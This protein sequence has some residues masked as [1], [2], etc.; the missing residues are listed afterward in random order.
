MRTP[1]I[2]PLERLLHR[3][4]MCILRHRGWFIY[5]QIVLFGL[6]LMFAHWRLE[7]RA[8]RDVLVSTEQDY[9][10]RWLELKR[11]FQMQ[12]NLVALVESDDLEKNRQFVERLAARLEAEPG[13]FENV[14]FKRD[15]RALGSKGLLFLQE[16]RL[17]AL[18]QALRDAEPLLQ[19]FS[20]VTNL[21]SLFSEVD[22]EMRV[23]PPEEAD[24]HPLTTAIPALTRIVQQGSGSLRRSGIP[25][26]PGITAL[27]AAGAEPQ[28]GEYIH[29]AEGTVYAISCTVPEE[30]LTD[31]A[32]VRLREL[33][34][35]AQV[36][37]PGVNVGVVGHPV[38]RYEERRQARADTTLASWVALAAVAL[39]FIFCYHEVRRPLK[40]T[41]CL[42]V[43]IGYTLGFATLT[44]GHLNILT[45]TVVP[46]LLGLAIDF[47]VH[48][49]TRFEEELRGGSP[50][51]DAID[52]AL[53]VSGSGI[54]TGGLATAA[55]FLAMTL[56]GFK[57]LREMGLIAG[58]GLLVCLAPMMTML[59]ALLLSGNPNRVGSTP[60]P[61]K[62]P[63][64]RRARFEQIWLKRPWIAGG[65][66]VALTLLAASQAHRVR[67]DYNLLNMQSQGLSAV[68]FE[69]KLVESSLRSGLACQIVAGS[70][71]QALA[72]ERRIL[73]LDTVAVVDSIAPLLAG[74][75][76]GKLDLVR[77]IREVSAKV[78]LAPMDTT[79]LDLVLLE[80]AL[81]SFHQALGGAL[82]AVQLAEDPAFER[83]LLSLREAIEDWRKLLTSGLPEWRT[84]KL[85]YF[86]QA[87]FRDLSTMLKAL[88]EQDYQEPLRAED[89]PTALRSRFI[90]RTG[91]FLLQVYPKGNVWER[92]PQE[93][94]VRELRTIDP[95][96]AGPPVR[97]YEHIGLLKGNF[98][99]GA[100][101]A[102]LAISLM[103]LLHFR[104]IICVLLALLPVLVGI[105]WTLG[106]MVLLDIAFNPVN[107][108]AFTLLIG[109][110]VSNGV[111]ILNRVTEEK[112]SGILSKSTGKAVLVS[113]LTTAAGFG[114]L[115]LAQHAG[116]A[117]LGQVMALGTTL[118]ML[119]TLAILPAVL[120]LLNRSRWRLAHGW[121]S[122]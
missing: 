104:N 102:L 118:C 59:P 21:P 116:I 45:I 64:G 4:A 121:L 117:S 58:G 14:L 85:T 13:L 84:E 74:D 18:L 9:H 93:A 22:A 73:Q 15:L 78:R 89:L 69:R 86:Q 109:I 2:H 91:S 68:V 43:G 16:Q 110:G 60:S 1:D 71:S 62:A 72:L 113:A 24:R 98:Q 115:M 87:L 88:Q 119:A 34:R 6:C 111:H 99:K 19:T 82:R 80:G 44:V 96:V 48:L 47:G 20:N 46:I 114:S 106:W 23:V 81:Q 107:M 70:I 49:I 27:F 42:M 28:P 39:T 50:V 8:D 11:E 75:Q 76:Q 94:F 52:K 67:F 40:A 38:L 122:H 79:P 36:E 61:R 54:C 56:T 5:P 95:K 83:Q 103:L 90:G 35:E 65:A 12:E 63:H 55:A 112:H 100:A 66:G 105:L 30:A 51:Y 26:S 32:I 25:P 31:Q 10:R 29:F 37:V 120:S 97:F 77:Q 41:A 92:G 17:E 57:G 101:Y 3:L 108:V 53:V 7:F 33:V